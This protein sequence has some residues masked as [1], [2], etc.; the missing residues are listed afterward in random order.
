MELGESLPQAAIREC[1]EETGV[2]IQLTGI[3]GTF[4]DP[5]RRIEFR[6]S[7]PEVRQEFSVVFSA[8]PVGGSPQTSS[9]SARVEWVP[10]DVIGD[11]RMTDAQRVRLH[12]WRRVAEGGQ[13]WIG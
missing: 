2:A 13:P 10:A 1:E 7:S 12:E 11:L 9:E 4:T 6:T 5:G 8:R 3:V